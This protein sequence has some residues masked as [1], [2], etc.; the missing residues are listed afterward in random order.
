MVPSLKLSIFVWL[1]YIALKVPFT[2]SSKYLTEILIFHF[3]PIL[4]KIE[5]KLAQ[6]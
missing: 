1:R 3:V 6:I 5:E 4:K 2:P